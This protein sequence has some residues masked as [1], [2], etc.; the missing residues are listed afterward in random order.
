LT[1][2]KMERGGGVIA[3]EFLLGES[4]HPVVTGGGS[5]ALSLN[6]GRK[7][8]PFAIKKTSIKGKER[9]PSLRNAQGGKRGKGGRPPT[10]PAYLNGKKGALHFLGRGGGRKRQGILRYAQRF[11]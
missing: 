9:S 5:G 2:C 4:M 6:G 8:F 11:L 10:L 3:D 1:P 7:D